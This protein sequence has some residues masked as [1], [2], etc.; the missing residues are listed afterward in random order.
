[1]CVDELLNVLL[2]RCC[3]ENL[4]RS[5]FSPY[6]FYH[7]YNRGKRSNLLDISSLWVL[8]SAPSTKSVR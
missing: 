6:D 2:G 3:Q 1:M 5:N 8:Q 7:P 4:D